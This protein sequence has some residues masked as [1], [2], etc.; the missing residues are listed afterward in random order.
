MLKLNQ[1]FRA[2][3]LP[4]LVNKPL[5][6]MPPPSAQMF[7][8]NAS[9]ALVSMANES[10]PRVSSQ[11]TVSQTGRYEGIAI[12]RMAAAFFVVVNHTTFRN[13]EAPA[14][15]ASQ[16]LQLINSLGWRVP[17]FLLLAGFLFARSVAAKGTTKAIQQCSKSAKRVGTLLLV[18]SAVY[19]L[20]PPLGSLAKGDFHEAYQYYADSWSAVWPCMLWQGPSYPL[21]F[22]ASLLMVWL[23]LGLFAKIGPSLYTLI[24]DDSG[25]F[26][27][28][29]SAMAGIVGFTV[30]LMDPV[31]ASASSQAFEIIIVHALLPLTFVLVGASL[32]A[33]R[34][35]LIK[36]A[37]IIS[38]FC[39]SIAFF[40]LEKHHEISLH[41]VGPRGL[42]M[43]GLALATTA[44]GVGLRL[45]ISKPLS[46]I[47][48]VSP[49]IYCIHMLVI[50][51]MGALTTLIHHWSA[52]LIFTVSVFLVSLVTSYALSR[53]SL[54]SRFVK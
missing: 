44:L 41:G 2:S 30:F 39:A 36:P 20:N 5:V 6:A 1:E 15:Q 51:R 11:A 10:M 3:N 34:N 42:S 49:G 53:F 27:P 52:N 14:N 26:L 24:S 19:L 47:W 40:I 25:K 43:S 45:P 28:I 31:P 37:V 17:F 29:T 33:W 13:A 16:A 22:L 12:I 21:W 48:N 9:S 7:E 23:I 18:W 35:W 4:P 38:L 32:W 8:S 46:P 50:S 54:T